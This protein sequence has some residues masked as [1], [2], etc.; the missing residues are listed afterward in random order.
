MVK[1][2]TLTPGSNIY[3]SYSAKY[4][5]KGHKLKSKKTSYKI[6]K[7]Q[8]VGAKKQHK[9]QKGGRSSALAFISS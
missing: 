9:L 4:N 6:K 1:A 5:N 7:N 2:F 3:Y 8:I